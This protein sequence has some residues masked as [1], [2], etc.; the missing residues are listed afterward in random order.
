[1]SSETARADVL[2]AIADIDAVVIFDE[3]TPLRLIEALRPDVLVKGA[4][5]Q[6][7]QIVG[8]DFV[9]SYGGRVLRAELRPGHSTTA[10][11]AR[12]GGR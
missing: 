6:I 1:V 2:S 12:M 3:D 7:S 11:I 9:M 5:Y 4:D 10:V 8:A